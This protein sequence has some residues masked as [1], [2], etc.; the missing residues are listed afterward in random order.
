MGNKEY[1]PKP[2]QA[3]NSSQKKRP[4]FVIDTNYS[5]IYQVMFD[6][7]Q[8]VGKTS[9][10]K[11][12]L[13]GKVFKTTQ[14]EYCLRFYQLYEFGFLFERKNI[15]INLYDC[16]EKLNITVSN[17]IA[18]RIDVFIFIYDISDKSTLI[19][20]KKYLVELKDKFEEKDAL[21]ILVGN[22]SDLPRREV[23]QKDVDYFTKEYNMISIETSTVTGEGIKEL[24]DLIIDN[25]TKRIM[26]QYFPQQNQINQTTPEELPNLSEINNIYEKPKNSNT[27]DGNENNF[28]KL[29]KEQK[30]KNEDLEKQNLKLQILNE[31]LE[32]ELQKERE[33]NSKTSANNSINEDIKKLL[34]ICGEISLNQ[35]ELTKEI[36]KSHFDSEENE[37]LLSIIISTEDKNTLYSII[38]KSTDKFIKIKEKFYENVPEFGK[39]ENLF[40]LNENEINESKTLEENGI[41]N[42]DLIIFKKVET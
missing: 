30:L 38:C 13:E 22:K 26:N 25:I 2:S 19:F 15:G 40:Y 24:F 12:Y 18:R 31:Q 42:S 34:I 8:K 28:E 10:I 14:K 6:G 21:L 29:Y 7:L 5:E 16:S 39:L 11:K 1:S 9:I 4:P 27:N 3:M 17:F 33:K 36:K 35:K 20:L 32:K 41:K 23:F 37:K